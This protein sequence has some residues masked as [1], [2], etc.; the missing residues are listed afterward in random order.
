[1]PGGKEK[2]LYNQLF[3][4]LLKPLSGSSTPHAMVAVTPK[5]IVHQEAKVKRGTVKGEIRDRFAVLRPIATREQVQQAVK[6]VRKRLKQGGE[7]NVLQAAVQGLTGTVLPKKARDVLYRDGKEFC[8]GMVAKAYGAA[9]IDLVEGKPGSAL[10]KDLVQSKK[11]KPVG[12]AGRPMTKTEK[13]RM[14]VIPAVVGGSVISAGALG[15]LLGGKKIKSLIR[16]I[17]RK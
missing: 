3:Y 7:Y 15:A 17:L 14:G 4:G 11:L 9:G 1:M 5:T 12:W 10:T 16:A 13:H 8:T 2:T 6:N